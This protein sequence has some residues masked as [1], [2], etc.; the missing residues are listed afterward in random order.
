M[1]IN[2]KKHEENIANILDKMTSLFKQVGLDDLLE[3]SETVL[4]TYHKSK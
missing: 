1:E 4:K 2:D 3:K